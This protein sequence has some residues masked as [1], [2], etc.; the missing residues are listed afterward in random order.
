MEAL[1]FRHEIGRYLATR[2]VYGVA[3]RLWSPRLAPLHYGRLPRP[4]A[5]ERGWVRLTVRLS[6]ICGSDLN[7]VTARDSLYLEPEASYPFVPGHEV[8]GE[9]EDAVGA[10]VD[11]EGLPL[12]RGDRVAVWPILGCRPRG[13]AACDSCIAGWDGLCEQREQGWPG[14][15]VAIGFNRRTGGGW[16]EACL[17]HHSQ[18]WRLPENVSD[19][20]ALLLDPSAAALASLL[21]TQ[22]S[23]PARTLVLGGGTVGLLIA[24]LHAALA[25]PGECELLV[26]YGTQMRA[27]TA[28]GLRAT[29]VRDDEAFRHWAAER[30][31][32][33]RKV[34]GY[35]DIHGG[36]YDRVIDAAGT[37]PSLRWSLA[38]VRPRGHVV[39]ATSA[40]SLRGVD[41]TPIWYREITVRGIYQYGPVPWRGTPTHPYHVL[42]PMLRDGR[43]VLGDLVTH[44]Y[45]L[46]SYVAAFETLT[47]R[48]EHA[49]VKVAFRPIALPT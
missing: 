6:G 40:P 27:A 28:Y 22:S 20:D 8:V 44:T 13:L 33:S 12:R 15:G 16:A 37:V 3:R 4:V 31:M 18:L 45:P 25:L 9:L 11:A 32:S 14:R 10:V 41:P 26:R 38:A 23:E 19:E 21:R 34:W 29:V 7:L 47:R 35:G 5:Q 36:T 46:T 43:L 48:R 17:A 30:G 39:L 2:A 1:E 49:A 24:R 42:L